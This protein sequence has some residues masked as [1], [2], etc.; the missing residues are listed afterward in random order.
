MEFKW[1]AIQKNDGKITKDNDLGDFI[2]FDNVDLSF[3]PND[4]SIIQ[5]DSNSSN[6]FI[7]RIND[8]VVSETK[9]SSIE[10]VP[11]LSEITALF[12]EK[13][14]EVKPQPPED[15][16]LMA[17]L[18]NQRDE[19]LLEADIVILRSLENGESPS[20]DWVAYRQELRDLPNNI[21][22]G[23]I[24]IPTF[25]T[26]GTEYYP[27]YTIEFSSWPVKPA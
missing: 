1:L 3:L 14:T 10:E 11:N 16:D 22:S 20:S 6:S 25:T 13:Q 2:M 9:I 4:I 19:L 21:E 17:W 8:G 15:E 23:L 18:R 7:Q 5:F 27:I 26:T 24:P 12:H